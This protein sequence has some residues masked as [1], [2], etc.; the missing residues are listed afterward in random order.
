MLVFLYHAFSL[1]LVRYLI[2]LFLLLVPY[3]FNGRISLRFSLRDGATGVIVS[4]IVLLPF[5]YFMARTGK[6]FVMLPAGTMLYQLLG[7]SFP[8]E[9][10]FRG[11]LQE[12]LGN[13]IKGVMIVSVLFSLMHSPRFVF[14]GDSY[15]LLTFFPSLVMGLLYWKTSNILP[16]LIFHCFSNIMFLGFL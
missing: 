12:K 6:V 5:W 3:L 15:S 1:S 14:Y 10:Y 9:V 11:F 4:V 7:I 13:T 16:S 2:P 8:E